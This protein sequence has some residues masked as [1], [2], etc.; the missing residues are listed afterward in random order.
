MGNMGFEYGVCINM[1]WDV[2]IMWIKDIM[3]SVAMMDV[4]VALGFHL[5]G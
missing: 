4:Q 5:G 3:V 1:G 2:H